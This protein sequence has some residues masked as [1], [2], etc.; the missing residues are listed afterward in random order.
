M[1]TV[2]RFV[3]LILLV[4]C[5]NA[6]A[7]EIERD[8]S[9]DVATKPAVKQTL[10]VERYSPTQ[11]YCMERK[12]TGSRVSRKVCQTLAAW[13]HEADANAMRTHLIRPSGRPKGWE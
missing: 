4:V 9:R 8:S 10:D 11:V 12:R 7:N 2:N 13:R 6:N 1:N 5:V 3:G